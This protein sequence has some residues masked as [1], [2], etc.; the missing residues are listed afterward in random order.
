MSVSREEVVLC[1]RLLL[2]REPENDF[3]VRDKVRGHAD[4]WQL[5]ETFLASNEYR[6]RLEASGGQRRVDEVVVRHAEIRQALERDFPRRAKVL[7]LGRRVR[8]RLSIYRTQDYAIIRRIVAEQAPQH[9]KRYAVALA[10]TIFQSFTLAMFAYLIGTIVNVIFKAKDFNAI[11]MLSLGWLVLFGLRGLA[12]YGQEIGLARAA[13]RINAE[14]QHRIF[15]KLLQQNVQFF[16]D[17]HSSE[18]MAN[19]LLGA[20]AFSGILNQLTLALGRDLFMLIWLIGL[21]VYINPAMSLVG[22]IVLPPALMGVE[23][24][25]DRARAIASQQFTGATNILGVMQETVQG[26]KIVKAFNLERAVRARVAGTIDDF[27]AAANDLAKVSSSSSPLIETFGGFAIALSCMYGGWQIL[28]HEAPPGEFVSFIMAFILTFDPARRLARLKIDLSAA[29]VMAYSTMRLLDMPPGEADDENLPALAVRE[30]RVAFSNV[31]FAYRAGIDVLRDVSLVAEPGR[32]TALVG[33]SGGGK[34]TIFNLLLRFYEPSAGSIAIDGHRIRDFSRRSLRD[35]ITYVGQEIY[36][37]HGTV[38][39]NILTG[40]A[41]ATEAELVA[42][43]KAAYAHDF[44]TTLPA[45]YDTQIGEAGGSLSMGQRQRIAIARALIKDARIVLLDEPTASLDSE[46]E[47]YVQE[48]L[49][50]LC[51]G[52]TTL[53]I[54]HRLNTIRHADR[55]YVI[56]SG[57]IV[58]AGEHDEL[59]RRD[60]RYAKFFSLQF[61]D[62]D[63]AERVPEATL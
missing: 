49:K 28:Q 52:R 55:I 31:T 37:F 19:A 16:S 43:A 7:D 25:V 11:V 14:T 24:L 5:I 39:E 1:Y 46:S 10:L 56:E 20:S 63:A 42:A 40:K 4:L 51:A 23:H 57:R 32:M 27:E 3:V 47:H 29:L 58:E 48:A 36:L 30:G 50:N 60:G 22:L 45:G 62:R 61:P 18:F 34:S 21:M 44:I 53:A 26:V 13:N 9:W 6:L 12:L 17:R 59:L 35:Q 15:Q 41:D 2:G 33:P 38:R 54:A 8:E